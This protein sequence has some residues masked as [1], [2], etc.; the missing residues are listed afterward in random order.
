MREDLPSTRL[1]IQFLNHANC[2]AG[3]G[4]LPLYRPGRPPSKL[5][6]Q[7]P[8]PSCQHD[9]PI[10]Q[11]LPV[12]LHPGP[13]SA[14]PRPEHITR[15]SRMSEA[16]AHHSQAAAALTRQ[17]RWEGMP[18]K[19]TGDKRRHQMPSWGHSCLSQLP[20]AAG[21]RAAK[22]TDLKKTSGINYSGERQVLKYHMENNT[23]FVTEKTE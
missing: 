12:S 5:R 20:S 10:S 8:Q 13:A 19:P 21:S 11:L 7:L 23:I 9:V 16:R 14:G 4:L 15:L 18:V 17:M 3:S 6:A 22:V 2:G 1:N